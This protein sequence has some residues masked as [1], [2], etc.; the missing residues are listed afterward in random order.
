MIRIVTGLT[1]DVAL[2]R[3]SYEFLHGLHVTSVP[4]KF[5]VETGGR[6]VTALLH[7]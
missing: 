2:N 1:N 6:D 3:I 7:L 5:Y 4:V